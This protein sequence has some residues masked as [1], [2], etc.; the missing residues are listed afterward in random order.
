M[1]PYLSFQRE[2][3]WFSGHPGRAALSLGGFF[4]TIF[5]TPQGGTLFSPTLRGISTF[6]KLIPKKQG[7][8]F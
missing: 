6:T 7:M 3:G 1:I 5:N 4:A 2:W 8:N